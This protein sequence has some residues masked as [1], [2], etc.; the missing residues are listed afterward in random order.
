[1]R[2]WDELCLICGLGPGGGPR[3]LFGNIERC[4]DTLV[5]HLQDMKLDLNLSEQEIREEIRTVLSLFENYGA[6]YEELLKKP[7]PG[8]PYFPLRDDS[9]HGWKAIA[10]GTFDGSGESLAT[11]ITD[12]T[13]LNNYLPPRGYVSLS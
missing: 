4:L 12:A 3:N 2:G 10:I 5:R 9:W 1:M 11:V 8:A 6:A 7:S 13:G